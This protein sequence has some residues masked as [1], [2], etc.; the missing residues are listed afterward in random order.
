MTPS[1]PRDDTRHSPGYRDCR[2]ESAS[3]RRTVVLWSATWY[4][5]VHFYTTISIYHLK[6]YGIK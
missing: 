1:P 3:V 6:S 5:D 2:E 4:H